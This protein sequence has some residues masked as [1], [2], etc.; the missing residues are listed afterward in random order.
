M[1][2]QNTDDLWWGKTSPDA[3][4]LPAYGTNVSPLTG[5]ST[6]GAPSSTTGA[7]SSTTGSSGGLPP[8]T[9]PLQVSFKDKFS[10]LQKRKKSLKPKLG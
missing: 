9:A 6:T 1:P 10:P 4:W 3:Q 8:V 7:P 5:S 2:L